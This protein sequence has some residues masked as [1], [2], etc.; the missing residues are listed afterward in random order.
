MSIRRKL[1]NFVEKTWYTT[2]KLTTQKNLS[3]C[4]F[5][6]WQTGVTPSIWIIMS[7]A[8]ADIYTIS[9]LLGHKSIATTT[10]YAAVVDTQRDAATDRVSG[11]FQARLKI[12][13]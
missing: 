7:T 9:K 3:R 5:A 2:S 4:G 10:V 8:G 13:T 12:L 1:A 6:D 11:F